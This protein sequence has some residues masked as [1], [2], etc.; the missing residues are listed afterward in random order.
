MSDQ[1]PQQ[2]NPTPENELPDVSVPN[3]RASSGSNYVPQPPVGTPTRQNNSGGRRFNPVL[4]GC[5]VGL[6]AVL[7]VCCVLPIV[8]LGGFG[9]VAAIVDGNTVSERSTE[10]LEIEDEDDINLE[11]RNEVGDVRIQG[12]DVDDI[13]VEIDRQASGLSE[14]DARDNLAEIEVDVRREGNRYIIETSGLGDN[15]NILNESHVD[16]RISVP[17][18]VPLNVTADNNVGDLS[19]RE[20][21]AA[22]RIDL[23]MN[24][25]DLTF[26]GEIANG[27]EH[28]IAVDVGEVDVTLSN[29]SRVRIDAATNVGDINSDLDLRDQQTGGDV[30]DSSLQGVYGEGRETIASLRI[31]TDVGDIN[32]DDD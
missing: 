19:V 4:I 31:R 12:A 3:E 2:Q 1:N 10:R 30:V 20:I 29:N 21:L 28:E 25:G 5:G 11:V 8:F 22:D 26:E 17:D 16:L 23:Q 24:V 18:D 6:V 27:G 32:L 15:I 9:A 7:L 13:Q 14:S